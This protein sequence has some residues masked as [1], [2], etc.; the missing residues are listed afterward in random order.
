MAGMTKS[1]QLRLSP[2]I[3][4]LHGGVAAFGAAPAGARTGMKSRT[5]VKE[6]RSLDMH[7]EYRSPAAENLARNNGAAVCIRADSQFLRDSG[8][9]NAADGSIASESRVASQM[10]CIPKESK[11]QFLNGLRSY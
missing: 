6:A 9:G 4:K 10:Q 11:E 8:H 5:A 7:S 1:P 3:A 2:E